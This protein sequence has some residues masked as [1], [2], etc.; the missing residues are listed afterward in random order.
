MKNKKACIPFSI[1]S[2]LFYFEV[3]LIKQCCFLFFHN[4]GVSQK[5]KNYPVQTKKM[6]LNYLQRKRFQSRKK[7]CVILISVNSNKVMVTQNARKK[8]PTTHLCQLTKKDEHQTLSG[9]SHFLSYYP[10]GFEIVSFIHQYFFFIKIKS[11]C[12]LANAFTDISAYKA[13]ITE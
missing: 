6:F 13:R 10:N 2:F 5:Q 11:N 8:S 3:I 1:F 12:Y 7:K 9:K 4:L